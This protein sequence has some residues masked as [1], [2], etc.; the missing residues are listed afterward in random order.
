VSVRFECSDALG[1]GPLLREL[2]GLAC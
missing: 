2:A 1:V